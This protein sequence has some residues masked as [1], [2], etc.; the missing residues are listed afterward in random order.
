M[1]L[2]LATLNLVTHEKTALATM[3]LGITALSNMIPS[4][5]AFSMTILRIMMNSIMWL[6]ITILSTMMVKMRVKQF[7]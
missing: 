6:S 3:M 4:I 5:M 2:S 7:F 1:Q